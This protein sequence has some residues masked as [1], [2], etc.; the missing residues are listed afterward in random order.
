MTSLL[1]KESK[2]WNE[3]IIV[4]SN[5]ANKELV[6]RNNTKSDVD[7]V[8]ECNDIKSSILKE[9]NEKPWFNRIYLLRHLPILEDDDYILYEQLKESKKKYSKLPNKDFNITEEEFQKLWK[10]IKVKIQILINENE[11]Y[12]DEVINRVLDFNLKWEIH[13]D[14]TKDNNKR[15]PDTLSGIEEY[16][17]RC[18]WAIDIPW[19]NKTL[20]RGQS[21]NKTAWELREVIDKLLLKNAWKDF[22]LI[23]NRSYA[24]AFSREKDD[25]DISID[26]SEKH[27][28]EKWYD[29]LDFSDKEV[30]VRNKSYLS[31]DIDN[32]EEILN[33]FVDKEEFKKNF[34][35]D[36]N[37]SILRLQNWI[38]NFFNDSINSKSAKSFLEKILTDTRIVNHDLHIFCISNL[39]KEKQS[40]EKI[41][42][43]FIHNIS[44]YNKTDAELLKLYNV[45]TSNNDLK[46]WIELCIATK[47][48][49]S[50]DKNLD[51]ESMLELRKKTDISVKE[52]FEYS[53]DDSIYDNFTDKILLSRL[54]NR[55]LIFYTKNNNE[56]EE[57][58]EI[59]NIN[60]ILENN[61]NIISENVWEWKS[62][63]LG[64][65]K[66]EFDN[67]LNY[68][69]LFYKAWNIN[70]SDT[71][72]NIKTRIELD[73][74]LIKNFLPNQKIILFFDWID[75]LN[76]NYKDKIKKYL[77]IELEK[78]EINIILGTRKSEFN[79]YWGNN[80]TILSF[81]KLSDTEINTFLTNIIQWDSWKI[82]VI[83]IFLYK[84][85]LDD[86]LKRSPLILYF[87][88]ELSIDDIEGIENRAFL[89][90]NIK[91]SIINKHNR[92]E[93][94]ILD[95]L[96][97]KAFEIFK[98]KKINIDSSK[99]QWLWLLLKKVWDNEYQFI[100]NSFYE[101]FLARYFSKNK[102]WNKKLLKEKDKYTNN[103]KKWRNFKPVISFY[104]ELL[105][106]NWKF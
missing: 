38:N 11:E 63:H 59:I 58:N 5:W 13:W 4:P 67:N 22:I 100:H 20:L 85:I 2:D 25:T 80:Y 60:D 8:L 82:N 39:L 101:F 52:I 76:F 55:K 48:N 6:I 94:W 92:L 35:I 34:S 54:I 14:K 98:N 15:V 64:R 53:V 36:D 17:D 87:L 57:E 29:Y 42:Q 93:S 12:N 7:C 79:E 104:W 19:S 45:L 49:L 90:E 51:I 102:K 77:T 40:N 21:S 74:K 96:G 72:E 73:I 10:N 44:K 1:P 84:W 61:V 41:I 37:E 31:I 88:T 68:F 78:K 69:T 27:F 91:K 46:L 70:K 9:C 32:F 26:E 83:K 28:E 43:N 105:V 66:L 18:I 75:E 81:K 71:F 3:N 56:E 106:N 65:L 89:Y 30:D 24:N 33:I 99:L 62:F 16:K 23:S 47:Q 97:E 95:D 86:D 50:P 103:W